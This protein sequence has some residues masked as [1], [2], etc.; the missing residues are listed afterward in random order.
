MKHLLPVASE[1]IRIGTQIVH[2]RAPGTVTSKGDRDMVS[3]V[4]YAVEDALQQFLSTETPE[5]GFLGE[6]NG[7]T[8]ASTSELRW[9][10]DPVDGTANFVRGLPLTAISLGLISGDE[11]ILGV[12]GMP[13]LDLHYAAAKGHGALR[14]DTRIHVSGTTALQDAIVAIGDYAV[15]PRAEERNQPRLQLTEQLATHVQRVRMFGS[16]AIDLAWV[17]EGRLDGS[18]MLANKP[19]DTSAGAAIAREAGAV[20]VDAEGV[21]HTAQSAATIAVTPGLGPPLLDLLNTTVRG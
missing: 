17:A 12:V 19:W 15:G 11:S 14:N 3:E 8:Y 4:D 1:A 16:A 21:P 18:L 13:F 7:A 2:N 9:V 20:V 10:L 6:E 5:I